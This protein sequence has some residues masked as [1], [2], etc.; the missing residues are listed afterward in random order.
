M[1]SKQVG[2]D[3]NYA[4]TVDITGPDWPPEKVASVVGSNKRAEAKNSWN[5]TS[6]IY[7][8]W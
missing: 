3:Q 8:N 7:F 2:Q 5:Y 4:N 1:P 6:G